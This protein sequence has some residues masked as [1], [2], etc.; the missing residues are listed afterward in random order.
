MNLNPTTSH[1]RAIQGAQSEDPPASEIATNAFASLPQD[2][3]NLIY[4]NLD[5]AHKKNFHL[6]SKINNEFIKILRFEKNRRITLRELPTE[7][8]SKK[9][10]RLDLSKRNISNEEFKSITTRFP[11][12]TEIIISRCTKI[13]DAGLAHLQELKGL[14]HLD[15]SR[16]YEITDAGLAHLQKLKGLTHLNI[17]WCKQI[18]D[19][20]LA[21][22]QELNGLITL[23][24]N[25]CNLIT[26]NGLAS[27]QEIKKL[28]Q[29][30][31]RHCDQINNTHL[32]ALQKLTGLTFLDLTECSQITD[33]DLAH[34]QKLREGTNFH[35]RG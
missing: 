19:A 30:C 14:T 20:G 25:G 10:F 27:L 9:E 4:S 31:L 12:I 34:I 8:S 29:L 32:V 5:S 35:L 23:Y 17:S 18:T 15:I 26:D 7:L 11:N 1:Q 16:C 22:L 6:I 13:T 24:L 21:S 33:A 2:S 3:L 28:D